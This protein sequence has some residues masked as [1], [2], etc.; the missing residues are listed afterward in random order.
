MAPSKTETVIEPF[1]DQEKLQKVELASRKHNGSDLSQY[2]NPSLQVT[3]SHEI[4][5]VE[6]P[7]PKPGPGDALLHVK[8]TGICG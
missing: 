1:V 6:A 3:A 4:K 2:T 5:M 7:I 8:S